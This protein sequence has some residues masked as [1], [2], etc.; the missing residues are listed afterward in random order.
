MKHTRI[1]TRYQAVAVF[2]IALLGLLIAPSLVMAAGETMDVNI[3]NA[4]VDGAYFKFEIQVKRTND[5]DVGYMKVGGLGNCDFYFNR[6]AAAFTG[7]PS[8]EDLNAGISG[9]PDYSFLVQVNGGYLQA[10]LSIAD[11][12][13]G[14]PWNPTLNTY[15]S[16]CTVVWEIATSAQS[17][18][19]WDELNSGFLDGDVDIIT[20]TY[21]GS[22][23]IA[24]APSTPLT[25]SIS[26]ATELMKGSETVTYNVNITGA[27]EMRG[28]EIEI[29]YSTSDFSSASL[30][31]GTFLSG[32]GAAGG[33][34]WYVT[35]SAGSDIANCA[36]LGSTSGAFGD[37]T[38]FTIGLTTEDVNNLAGSALTLPSVALRDVDNQEITCDDT[39]GA[40]ITIDSSSPTME[41]ISPSAGGYYNTAPIFTNFGF[42]DNYAL[43]DG[44]YQM[45]S[46]SGAWSPLFTDDADTAWDSDP[47]PLPTSVWNGLG[48]GTHTIYFKATDDAGNVEGEGGEWSWQFFKDTEAPVGTMSISFSNVT[49]TGMN[50]TGA[51]LT[52]ATQGDE[53]Y[54]FDCTT[55]ATWDRVRTI[56]D[57]VNECTGMAVNT[58]YTFK[59]Q[60][61]DNVINSTSWS[62]EYS[63]YTLA[64]VPGT[65]TVTNPAGSSTTLGVQLDVN[66]NPAATEFAIQETGGQYVQ[67]G[68]TLGA[69]AVWQ[70]N[71]TWG[72][73]TVTGLSIN[74][75]YT[76]K[77]KA[78][79]GDNTETAFGSTASK[80]TR[81][82]VPGAAVVNNPSVNSLDVDFGENSNPTSVQYAIQ[83]TGGQYV[84]AN[85]TLGASA[86][87]QIAST[88]GTETVTVLTANT[89]YTF[90]VKAKNGD[91]TETAFG[92]SAALYTLSVPPTTSTVTCDKNTSTWYNTTFTFTAVDGFG[93]GYIQYYRYVWDQNATYTSWNDT[94]TEWTTGTLPKVATADGSWYLHIKGYN[95][96]NVENSTVD[97][98]PYFY[99]GTAPAGALS[100]SFSGVTTTAMDVTGAA[101]EDASQGDEYYQFDCTTPDT[102]DRARTI[103][104][105]INECTGMTANTGYTFKYQGSDGVVNYNTTSWSSEYS[106]YTLSV[107][108]TTST[109]TCDKSTS[110]WY[111][112][113]QFTFT[114]EGNFGAGT[115]QYYRYV[116][117]QSATYTSWNDTET[118]WN[119]G[120]LAKNAT[121]DGNNWYLHIKGYNGD[122][123][124]N[125]TVD[126]GPYYYDATPP[127]P[128]TVLSAQTT[129][130]T[131]NSVGLS[132][133]NPG[134]KDTEMLQVQIWAKGFGYYPEYD[135]GG[136]TSPSIPEDPVAASTAGWTNIQNANISSYTWNADSTPALTV[137]DF[138]Y[139]AVYVEDRA[140]NFSS[141][142]SNSAL[143]YWLGDVNTTP[144]GVVNSADIGIL[145]SAFGTLDEETGYNN[146]VDVGPTTDMSRIARPTTD[147][148]IDFEDLMV[149]AMNYG[150]TV[151]GEGEGGPEINPIILVLNAYIEGGQLI[152]ELELGDNEGFVKGLRIP[153]I[154]GADLTVESVEQ[155][156][157]WS[158]EDFFIY[159]DK[160]NVVEINGSAL[161]NTAIIEG[162]GSVATI[163]FNISGN[164]ID[165]EFG[166]ASARTIENEEIEIICT[167]PTGIDTGD[168]IPTTF[169]LYQ[170]YPNPFNGRTEIRFDLPKPSHVRISVYNVKGQLVDVLEDKEFGPGYHNTYW[171]VT[172]LSS[173]IYFYLIE[174]E[175]YIKLKKMMLVRQAIMECVNRLPRKEVYPVKCEAIFNR[176]R[177]YRGVGACTD[178]VCALQN[179]RFTTK[180]AI[181]CGKLCS[182]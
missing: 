145:S 24:V 54:E 71:A 21:Y 11:T 75:Q 97:L 43:D 65:P 32:V 165:I 18:V 118:E 134:G 57:N 25:I 115:I 27:A 179:D 55:S 95:G 99:D 113:A 12:P 4:R 116:W 112:T 129:D 141:V 181:E 146:V 144:D 38:L 53:Y 41:P 51:D 94:E 102:W 58:E 78:R 90:Q 135:D 63:K 169:Q 14:P 142:I 151:K 178:M 143:C 96:D 132:W 121:A 117:D 92:S 61:S 52:D 100:I 77:V 103:N 81:A 155:G 10:K 22:G 3:S 147:N 148:V 93:A 158:D 128:V 125:G 87:W 139:F 140:G 101:L 175:N 167:G 49:T 164:D 154:F 26:P 9:N 177:L 120:T 133:T 17:E 45:D 159:T 42:D 67:A 37:G 86:V 19:T 122:N 109:V 114:A 153:I 74:T 98:G 88:W 6:N 13:T 33:T 137:R 15:E 60:G 82:N 44:F 157:I 56:T 40:V 111:N 48:D 8:Y 47:W 70:T 124:E 119:T 180:R 85:G 162:N 30:S 72:T 80:Y 91:N 46:Y 171:S 31:E 130:N 168:I 150:N 76:F 34:E 131:N 163:T 126:L 105:R 64:N 174:T 108:P 160:D 149:F 50:V 35:G 110:T 166:E 138:Y 173:G 156:D 20:A 123:V 106:K 84:Q 152:A 16:V 104:D 68:G 182:S 28:F 73:V 36:I 83:E 172:D 170:N 107:P 136:G 29:D 176:E 5:W 1:T 69:S 79:N 39:T 161:G 89:Q 2:I 66:S 7:D 59:Y 23:D 62:S 127:D